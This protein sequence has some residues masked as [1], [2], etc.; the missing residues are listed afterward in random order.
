[1]T[2]K[3][4]LEFLINSPDTEIIRVIENSKYLRLLG[5]KD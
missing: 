4:N 3:S 2:L 5:V 1:M